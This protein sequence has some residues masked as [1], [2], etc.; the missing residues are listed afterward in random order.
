MEFARPWVLSLLV[1]A[2]VPLVWR[3]RHITVRFSSF[4]ILP[5]DPVSRS[6]ALIERGLATLF[7]VAAVVSLSGPR[8]VP[9]VADRWTE[10]ARLVFVV[11][12]SASMFSPWSGEGGSGVTK[13]TA[14]KEAVREFVE[15]RAGDPVALIGFGKSSILY[16]PL[17]TDHRRFKETLVLLQSDMGDTVIDTALLRALELL[18]EQAS[19]IGSQ[20]VILLSDGAGRVFQPEE[21]GQRFRAAGVNFYWVRI[22]GGM[23]GNEGLDAMLSV[24]GE[25]GKRF[26]VGERNELPQALDAVGILESGLIKVASWSE[27]R[28]WT[29][30]S[31]VV[32]FGAL[33]ALGVFAFGERA[34]RTSEGAR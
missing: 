21:I 27:G 20:A 32:A 18:G 8:S 11:D 31:W 7:V 24:L 34:I 1:L 14:A 16:T 2:I 10:G 9:G 13:I 6:L 3:R 29:Q 30:P 17:T 12:Q 22:E 33:L 19:G 5:S 23:T 15:R 26:V 4:L 28:S 25:W